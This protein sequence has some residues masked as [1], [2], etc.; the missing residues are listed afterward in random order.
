MVV[1]RRGAGVWCVTIGLTACL[2]PP[3]IMDGDSSST[4]GGSSSAGSGATSS[5][6]SGDIMTST[7]SGSDSDAP[8]GTCDDGSKNQGESDV[9]CGGPC[10]ACPAGQACDSSSDCATQACLAGVCVV[11]KCLGD[12]ECV[13]LDGACTRGACELES[14]TCASVPDRE[15]ESCDDG[16]LCSPDSACKA[17]VCAA[18]SKVDCSGFESPCTHGKCDAQSGACVAVDVADGVGCDDGDNC[19]VSETCQAGSCVTSEPGA[20]FFEDFSAPAGWVLDELW[21]FGAAQ[22]SPAGS[23]GADPAEDHSPGADNMLAG[24]VIG[25]LDK[26]QGHPRRCLTSPPIDASAVVG[27][28]WVTFWRHLHAPAQPKVVLT[29]DVWNGGVWKN[30]ST[31]VE[32]L[33]DDA[34][35]T[36][37]ELNAT[38]NE[39]DDFKVRICV[40]RLAGAPDF[41]GWSIDDLTVAPVA[42]TP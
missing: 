12:A 4:G 11:P 41:A 24:T 20:L 10:E 38:G 22:A 23:G 26:L 32:M 37:V 35:W 17:G 9:D 18:T 27:P 1:G 36:L 42:C 28:L 39:A 8:P 13:A 7:G 6:G 3:P 14:F 30:L 33:T 5:S 15:G 16:S 31:G 19:T 40:E 2:S 25:G 29:V 34:G 21:E